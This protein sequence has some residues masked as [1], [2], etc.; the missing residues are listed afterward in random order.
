MMLWMALHQRFDAEGKQGRLLAILA[1]EAVSA[2]PAANDPEAVIGV[3]PG[4]NGWIAP[5][6]FYILDFIAEDTHHPLNA[7]LAANCR[8]LP[9]APFTG[10]WI[11][12]SCLRHPHRRLQLLPSRERGSIAGVDAK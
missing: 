11:E 12:T 7:S 4:P 5:H 9:V 10:A 1:L 8:R 2:E 6:R 3:H